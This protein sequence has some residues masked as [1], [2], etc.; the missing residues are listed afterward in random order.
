[1]E[2]L[3]KVTLL[4]T[5]DIHGFYMPWDYANDSKTTTGGLT[6]ISTIVK[7]I[8]KE[9]PHTVLI[10]NGDLIQGNSAEHFLK[11][12]KY[13]GIEAINKMEY[14]IYNMGNHEFNFGMDHLLN[15][16]G[17]FEG[18]A[19]MGNLYRK[20]N[21]MRFMN[22]IYYVNIGHIRIGFISLNTPLVRKFESKRGNLKNYDVIDA[23]YE[24]AKLL[25]EVGPVDALIGLF[26][27]GDFNEN[28]EPFTGVRDLLKYVDGSDKIDAVFGGHMHQ[29]I[30]T[31]INETIFL[32]P[33]CYGAGI[34]RLDLYFDPNTKD[35]LV[36]IEH[37]IIRVDESVESDPE[38]E[39]I[40]KPYHET[41][42][43]YINEEVGYVSKPLSEPVDLAGIPQ[44]NVSQTRVGD[45]FTD[46][47]LH[48][49][50]ADIV[51]FHFDNPYPQI[52]R[53]RIKRKYIYNAYRYA[54]GEVT[55]YQI[56]GRDLKLYMEW[57]AE[58]FKK[59]Q[60]GDINIAFEEART[61]SKYSTFDIFGNIR[62]KIDLTKEKG[63]RITDLS[64]MDG[65]IIENDK[66]YNLGMNKYRM[67]FLTS[68]KGP[69]KGKKIKFNW[70]SI[71]N[72]DIPFKGNIRTLAVKYFDYLEDRTYIV[73]DKNTWSIIQNKDDDYLV[74]KART[75]VNEG[76]LL[77]YLDEFGQ[78]D[79]NRKLNLDDDLLE[80]QI[81]R[82]KEFYNIGQETN[83]RKIL[84]QYV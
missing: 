66:I 67:D 1:M 55:V 29:I 23:N 41:L 16:V 84:S 5:S 65:S 12:A 33:G 20:R 25:K 75:L 83:L 68:E 2:N 72:P 27:M 74:E 38:L 48:Y 3:V 62:Y 45:F 39:K 31:K 36:K 61:S 82:L 30:N 70:T 50:P 53:T 40:L 22:G 56:S 17:Q 80:Y 44:A 59:A 73:E 26:H 76:K 42:V 71:N 7:N 21:T 47:M 19:M 64:L 81:S 32:E 49:S 9:N 51:A 58:F 28:D 37:S 18:V 15:V 14:E 4:C 34:A 63:Q 46:V 77:L 60:A 24:L 79:L 6:R 11:N 52:N 78:I 8:R 10:D 43:N 69:L 35:P 13:P 57:S 54:G